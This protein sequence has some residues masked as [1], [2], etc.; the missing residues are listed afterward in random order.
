MLLENEREKAKQ[1]KVREEERQQD[2]RAQE[3]YTRM[4]EKQE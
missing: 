2:I 4:L 3:E 1:E